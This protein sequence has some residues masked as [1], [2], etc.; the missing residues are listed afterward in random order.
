ML[1]YRK[2]VNDKL[3]ILSTWVSLNIGAHKGKSAGDSVYC[4]LI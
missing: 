4:T 1:N 2:V 3:E